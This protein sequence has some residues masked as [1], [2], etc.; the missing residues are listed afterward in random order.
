VTI[1]TDLRADL[2]SLAATMSATWAIDVRLGGSG[3]RVSLN[4]DT[5]VETMSVIKVPILVA[6]FRARDAGNLDLGRRVTLTADRRRV[7]T[8]V[9]R[10]FGDGLELT[11]NDAAV[12]MT[13]VS[14]NTATDIC[15]EAIGGPDAV[16]RE[17]TALGFDTLILG[18]TTFDWFRALAAEMT[19]AA[20][21]FTERELWANGY[22]GPVGL[23]GRGSGTSE[24]IVAART[25]FYASRRRAFGM[26]SARE[27]VDL[28]DQIADRR[29][30]APASCDEMLEML[31][32]QTHTSRVPRYAPGSLAV[33]AKTG[34]F[35]PFVANDA[36]VIRE[37]DQR[38]ATY[39]VMASDYH[40]S[41]GRLE[42]AMAEMGEAIL[43]HARRASE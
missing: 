15:I 11:L 8:G 40:G 14:D 5:P 41:Y 30:A 19:P 9:L 43:V 32:A 36:G 21:H 12:L 4:A 27:L 24:A 20:A 33:A 18:G 31:E 29:C 28:L 26:A 42:D 35:G 25:S 23:G 1:G 37:A 38:M 34:V 16:N 17:M 10:L 13:A 6:L 3:E 2:T 39:A 7:G 22:P